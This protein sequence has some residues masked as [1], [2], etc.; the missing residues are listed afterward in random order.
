MASGWRPPVWTG[1]RVGQFSLIS[2]GEFPRF[3]GFG[4]VR[5][6]SDI[7]IRLSFITPTID[8]KNTFVLGQSVL[9]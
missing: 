9:E 1:E 6:L 7:A 5:S 3:Q 2:V 4:K 8:S